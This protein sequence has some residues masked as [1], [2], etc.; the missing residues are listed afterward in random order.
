MNYA[1]NAFFMKLIITQTVSQ[2]HPLTCETLFWVDYQGVRSFYKRHTKVE[3]IFDANRRKRERGNNRR[4]YSKNTGWNQKN[5]CTENV[6]K[7][8]SQPYNI[9]KHQMQP[10]NSQRLFISGICLEYIQQDLQFAYKIMW[11]DNCSKF[12]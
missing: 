8:K 12:L 1:S 4:R 2:Y 10:L 9:R 11:S 3:T 6:H 7:N 5:I